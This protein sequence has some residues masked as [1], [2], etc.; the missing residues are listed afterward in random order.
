MS[1]LA[2]DLAQL[3]AATFTER[4]EAARRLKHRGAPTPE[5]DRRVREALAVENVPWVRG[6]LFSVLDGEQHEILREG[7]TI[8]APSWAESL[9]GFEQDLAR[10]AITLATSRVLHEV[11]AVVGRAK[12]AAS[13]DLADAY[14]AS[15]TA[16]EL[17]FLADTCKALRTLSSATKAPQPVEF[18]L[19]AELVTFAGS[20]GNELLC[21]IHADGPKPF[22]VVTDRTLLLLAVRNTV[23]NAVEAT[24]AAGPADLARPIVV[25]WGSNADGVHVSIIDRGPGPPSFLAALRSAGVSTKEGHPGYG[26]ATASEAL[27]SIDGSVEIRRNDRGGATVVLAWRDRHDATPLPAAAD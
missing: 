18:D 20:L 4:L 14:P 27:K 5:V 2:H 8:P 26:L 23:L 3:G 10:E 1:D 19:G 24:L 7:L 9:S 17:D 13:Q 12:L 11:A 6:A 15:D 25:T 16:T 21:P 22:V